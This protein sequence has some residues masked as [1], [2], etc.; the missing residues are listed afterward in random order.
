MCSLGAPEDDGE[1]AAAVRSRAIFAVRRTCRIARLPMVR[2][3]PNE[4]SYYKAIITLFEIGVRSAHQS[5]Y[6][7]RDSFG[8]RAVGRPSSERARRQREP[9]FGSV[10]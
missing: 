7:Y 1:R 8:I 2:D 5:L 9:E 3:A 10:S 4:L 6:R